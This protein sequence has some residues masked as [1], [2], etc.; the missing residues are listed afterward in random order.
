MSGIGFLF[1]GQGAQ[2]PGMGRRISEESPAS[3]RLYARAAEVLGYDLL[4]K[5]HD[6]PA[7]ELD[8]TVISQPAIFVTSLAA[9]EWLRG[10]RPG[11][12]DSCVAAAGLSLG[13]Y[14]ALVFAGV[15]EFED[16]LAVVQKRGEAMQAAS[17]RTPSGMVSLLLLE[18]ERVQEICDQAAEPGEVLVIANRLG[19]GNLVVS[20][21]QAACERAVELAEASGGRAVRLSVA[22]AFHTSLMEP[23]D[24]QVAS[25]LEDCP[26]AAPRIPVISNVDAQ[27]HDDPEEIRDLLVRQVKSP[28]LWADTMGKLIESGIEEFY[29]IGPGRVLTGLLKRID[30]KI[31]CQPVNDF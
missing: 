26:M 3:A 23:A 1:P 14:T 16:A 6:G 15:M 9:L 11:L 20:G 13:E 8:S 5:C 21:H 7:D 19:P 30:R 27:A 22:G 18:P 2:H 24:Q 28:V 4:A 25:A 29:E 10:D 17:D 31:R 12:I